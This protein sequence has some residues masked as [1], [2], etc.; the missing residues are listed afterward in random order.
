MLDGRLVT[1][2]ADHVVNLR[3]PEA[4][5]AAVLPF[6]L[7]HAPGLTRLLLLGLRGLVLV[8]HLLREVLRHL[9][10]VARTSRVYAPRPPVIDRRSI[11]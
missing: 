2:E 6:L 10:V 1:I 11:T 4:F 8:D 5:D 9:L 3:A 7:E